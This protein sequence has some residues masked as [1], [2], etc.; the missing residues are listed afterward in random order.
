MSFEEM[1]FSANETLR[2]A[3]TIHICDKHHNTYRTNDMITYDVY[4]YHHGDCILNT[5]NVNLMTG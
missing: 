3:S 2:M 5:P 4:K 1:L